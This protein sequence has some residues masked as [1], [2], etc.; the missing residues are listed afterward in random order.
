M[1]VLKKLKLKSSPK[2]LAVR[3]QDKKNSKLQCGVICTQY[4]NVLV[5]RN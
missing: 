2:I 5:Q 4:S 1:K 3:G